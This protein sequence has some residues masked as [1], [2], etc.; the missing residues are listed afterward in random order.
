MILLHILKMGSSLVKIAKK[1]ILSKIGS[2]NIKKSL[3]IKEF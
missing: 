2:I 3:K 1:L